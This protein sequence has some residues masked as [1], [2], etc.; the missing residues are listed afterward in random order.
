MKNTLRILGLL[1]LTFLFGSIVAFAQNDVTGTYE[2]T[3]KMP[4]APE[5]KVSI[6]LK[7]EGGKITGQAQH[8]PKTVPI[9]DAKLENGTLTLQ[10]DKDHKYVA[11]V[12]GDK[13]VGEVTD[14]ATK[15]PLEL[16]KVK[17]A[18]PAA[19]NLNGQWDGVADAQGQPFPFLLTL[20]V[21]GE[22]VTGSSSSQLGESVLKEGTWKDGKL[23]FQLEG[24]N[25]TISM[26][27]T[28]V[29]GKLSGEFDFAGQLQGRW[30]A[31]KKN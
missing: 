11:K 20:K 16:T 1:T 2:G 12:D 7:S 29:E 13:L 18:A 6:E 27:A 3:V 30:V 14:G 5:G 31:V 15:F 21:D 25:G 17:P 23:A 10:F 8:G 19:F 26:T 22:T 9:T 28:V 24:Q 4:G